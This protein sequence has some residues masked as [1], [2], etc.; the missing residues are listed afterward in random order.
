METTVNSL[1][2]PPLRFS[3]SSAVRSPGWEIRVGEAEPWP[4]LKVSVH[5][6][7]P[8][9]AIPLSGLRFDDG[10]FW[11]GAKRL[12]SDPLDTLLLRTLLAQHEVEPGVYMVGPHDFAA[13]LA[14]LR[15]HSPACGYSEAARVAQVDVLAAPPEVVIEFALG[16][17]PALPMG[18]HDRFCSAG[19]QPAVSPASSR[20]TVNEQERLEQ[21]REVCRLEAGD[22]ADWKSALQAGET[23]A[24]RMVARARFYCPE[25]GRALGNPLVRAAAYW[26]F[27]DCVAPSVQVPNDPQF[28]ALL[29]GTAGGYS[30]VEALE[31]LYRAQVAAREGLLT[32]RV[33]ERL[34]GLNVS[35]EA[36]CR[37]TNI[38]FDGAGDLCIHSRFHTPDGQVVPAAALAE[39][40]GAWV[41]FAGRLF[42]LPDSS[43]DCGAPE[44]RKLSGDAIADF[45]LAELL[46]FKTG[47]AAIAP[48]VEA[49]RVCGRL[50]P[51]VAVEPAADVP[52]SSWI[53]ARGT[54]AIRE[55]C[56]IAAVCARWFFEVA[57]APGERI[58]P[59]EI[60][61]AAAKGA[62]YLRRGNVFVRAERQAVTDA[63]KTLG[64]LEVLRGGAGEALG[65]KIPELL[66]W[67]R[68]ATADV[69]TPWN[70]YVA[71]AVRGAHQ[72]K[73]ELAA[74][75][76]RLDVE[77][78]GA[79]TWF[80]FDAQ[81]DCGGELLSEEELRSLVAQGR[82]WFRKG[83][84]WIKV[85]RAA[86][87]KLD[88]K[89][90]KSGVVR[91]CGRD[92]RTRYRFKPA[93]RERVSGLFSLEGSA[94]HAAR[95]RKFLDKLRGF[96][97][98]EAEPLP[99]GLALELRPYQRQGFE[100]LVFL[101]RYGLNGILAD[102]MGL[103]KT[104]Q[105][106]AVLT[107]MK[108]ARGPAPS[109]V[110]APTSLLDNWRAEAFKF[111]PGLRVLAYRGSA[112]QRDR[113]RRQAH[114]YDVVLGTYATVR[115]DVSLLRGIEWRCVILDEAHFIK[116]SAA[117]TT[118]A[119]KT[120]P[121][122]HR[123]ALT[124]TPIQNRLAELW[125]LFDFLMPGFL[126]R[127]GEFRERWEEP[128]GKLQSGAAETDEEQAEGEQALEELRQ[129]L[130][131]FVLRRLKADV[132]GELPPKIENDIFCPLSPEQAALYRAFA[133]SAE[134]QRAVQEVA[135]KGAG[136]SRAAILAALTALRGICNHADLVCLP[137]N[138]G[139]QHIARPLPGFER[140]SGKFEALGELLQQCR[141]GGHRALIFS[142][143][144]TM[145]DLL[146]HYLEQRGV[147]WLRLDGETPAGAR[148]GLVERFNSDPRQDTFLISTRAGGT[149]LNL[150]GADTV[151]FYDHD[152]NPANDQQAQDRAHRIG[153]QRTVNVYR[154]ICRGTME[155]K[156]LRRQELKRKLA[157]AVVPDG[158]GSMGD[159]SKA[160]LLGLFS[161]SEEAD[162]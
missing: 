68:K 80:A 49:A 9:G 13:V 142:Q 117:A 45:L 61:A 150:T 114:E 2:R 139:R 48:E 77:E 15:Q 157:A 37:R 27:E 90:R 58:E 130:R 57:E 8:E 143:L 109:L 155:E 113:L 40:Q 102:D 7:L 75:Q 69:Q 128:I 55:D 74:L 89:V 111:S 64:G 125:S 22:T 38:Y 54:D 10:A 148:Q 92:G 14:L 126:G 18:A 53:A 36:L 156:I 21:Q 154:L 122:Q 159:L 82:K 100:W 26:V 99:Q 118:K 59:V 71:E 65:E 43:A 160:E 104:A 47:G 153:Q 141:E 78:G 84:A 25:T 16:A 29:C 136:R 28:Q 1:E 3:A 110:V 11:R 79:D 44:E 4:A 145:L 119:L 12:S 52:Q 63:R 121:A 135:A 134:A 129:H 88:E 31:L 5:A 73:D 138:A 87:R 112:G 132:A 107:W 95:Y 124:G 91:C 97:R 19:F 105:A 42:R 127:Q 94:I 116:N 147:T 32:V 98:I 137:K 34:A 62:R 24:V 83:K 39:R 51:A 30:G 86:L 56:A 72:V 20:Q 76:L 149:G 60:L 123:L 133:D 131:P 17:T 33:D 151:I 108:A 96:E 41:R 35:V 140:R 120:I 152:W 103:G 23:P 67:A 93:A 162:A 66:A 106:I 101:A 161:L 144:T 50:K 115:N 85:D 70:V 6:R 158:S 81:F 46:C 146:G